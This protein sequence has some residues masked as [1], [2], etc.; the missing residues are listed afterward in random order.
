[1]VGIFHE[2]VIERVTDRRTDGSTDT[3]SYRDA[4]THLK[5]GLEERKTGRHEVGFGWTRDNMT[6]R[7][8]V[9]YDTQNFDHHLHHYATTIFPPLPVP[10]SH[11]YCCR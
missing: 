3:P 8:R 7:G 5:I 2:S 10:P 1:M 4:R 9:D 6:R 11:R